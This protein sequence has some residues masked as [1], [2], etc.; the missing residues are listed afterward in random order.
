MTYAEGSV[1]L[2]K[3]NKNLDVCLEVNKNVNM[4]CHIPSGDNKQIVVSMPLPDIKIP[5]TVDLKVNVVN[6]DTFSLFCFKT[7]VQIKT[8]IY[9]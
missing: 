6:G 1:D 8:I 2:I 5:V 7:K 4:E 9:F 3:F